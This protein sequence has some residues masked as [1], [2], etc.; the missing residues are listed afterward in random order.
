MIINKLQEIRQWAQAKIDGGQ[1][2]PWAW[3]QYMKLIENIDVILAGNEATKPMGE[4]NAV[5][6]GGKH[7]QL[8]DD[9]Y[10]KSN[11]N[12]ESGISVTLP[13]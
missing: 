5:Q 3:F 7:I 1:E 4:Q 2:P 12:P 6:A 9:E 13:I 11:P 10:L 8:V